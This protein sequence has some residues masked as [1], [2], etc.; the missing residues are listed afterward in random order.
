M[1]NRVFP[2]RLTL[3]YAARLVFSFKFSVFCSPYGPLPVAAS[4]S[5]GGSRSESPLSEWRPADE[6][7]AHCP[8][9]PDPEIPELESRP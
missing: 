9:P 1:L 7:S 6:Y 2:G 8:P 5:G 4:L 3:I